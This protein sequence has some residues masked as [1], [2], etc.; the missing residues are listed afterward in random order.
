MAQLDSSIYLQMQGP[1]LSKIGEG[2]E[3]GIRLGDMMRQRKIQEAEAQKQ[4]TIK[5]AYNNSYDVSPDGSR[6][7]N[8]M[9]LQEFLG[10]KGYAQE[11]EA[12]NQQYKTQQAANL[13]SDVET[14]QSK[15]S[16]ISSLLGTVKDQPS[17]EA[18]KSL[19]I[20][21]GFKEAASLPNTYDPQIMN[22]LKAQYG[23]A[24]MSYEKQ[25]E[26]SRKREESQARLMETK[27]NN[28][29]R[30]EELG[31]RRLE[32]KDAALVKSAEKQDKK[33]AAVTEI[34]DRYLN[35]KGEIANLRNLIDEDG[36]YDVM[37]PQNEIIDQKITSIATDMAKLVDP[38]S[39]ARESEVAAFKKMLFSPTP[40]IQ[41]STAKDVLGSFEKM[42]DDR[43]GTAYKV[44]GLD[45]NEA[46][47]GKTSD[48]QRQQPTE[49]DSQA[50]QWAQQNPND[51]R[52]A[53]IIES[54]K[55]KGF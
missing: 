2:F 30:R 29:Y 13:K 9:K 45:K 51:P 48:V 1:D 3:R 52:A 37:G 42:V 11:G 54:L 35:M 28:D 15:N 14:E 12:F 53:K 8:P 41:N 55:A 36:T 50:Y 6:V 26:D 22:S 24:S 33:N 16:F 20:S 47:T 5:E 46:V 38:T 23:L 18:A 43:L 27:Q 10:Q 31:L 49:Q 39:V 44:R 21:K 32:R 34:Q 40:F 7:L 4:N 17:Y 19:A 25:L